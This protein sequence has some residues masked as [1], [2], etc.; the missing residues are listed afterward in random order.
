MILRTLSK[1]DWE[2][3]EAGYGQP[4][5]ESFWYIKG[6]IDLDRWQGGPLIAITEIG[7]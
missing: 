7:S 4:A 2:A 3:N 1:R 5:R 6:E